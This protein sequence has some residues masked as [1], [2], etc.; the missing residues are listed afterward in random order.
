MSIISEAAKSPA[1]PR[2]SLN[3]RTIRT[4]VK[5]QRPGMWAARN[6]LNLIIS[7]SGSTTWAL[8]YST[9]DG[10]RRLMKLADYEPV[11]EATLAALVRISVQ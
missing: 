8:R 9:C 2:S 7:V 10:K 3:V 1:K 5:A 6:G 4:L 11:D